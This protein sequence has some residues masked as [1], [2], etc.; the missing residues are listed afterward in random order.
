MPEPA[1]S[2]AGP[3]RPQSEEA[4][5]RSGPLDGVGFGDRLARRVA[6][7][8]SQIVLGLDPDPAR[9]WPRALELAE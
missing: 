4:P 8:R 9:L 5:V 3:R 6:D 1:Q 2:V 7:R